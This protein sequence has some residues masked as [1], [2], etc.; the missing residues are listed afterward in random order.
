MRVIYLTHIVQMEQAG[1]E[2]STQWQGKDGNEAKCWSV[3]NDLA[4][5]YP[6]QWTRHHRPLIVRHHCLIYRFTATELKNHNFGLC[7]CS[8]SF[9]SEESKPHLTPCNDLEP[10]GLSH[11]RRG[12]VKQKLGTQMGARWRERGVTARLL[13]GVCYPFKYHLPHQI[14]K[15]SL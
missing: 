15:G 2:C 1:E 4:G 5:I 13:T 6:E 14:Q 11:E 3:V 10:H 12:V 9:S 7:L 8:I